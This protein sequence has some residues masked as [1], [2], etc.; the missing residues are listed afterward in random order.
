MRAVVYDLQ[1]IQ[2]LFLKGKVQ[3]ESGV[4]CYL[5]QQSRF[6]FRVFLTDAEGNQYMG[7]LSKFQ[8]TPHCA[9]SD[10][11]VFDSNTEQWTNET[12]GAFKIM[13]TLLARVGLL[14]FYVEVQGAT[15]QNFRAR[16]GLNHVK[17][18]WNLQ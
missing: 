4:S 8:D 14:G 9:L 6:N 2:D 7:Q 11:F 17:N 15:A 12:K 3:L 16:Q 5:Q 10:I 1:D 18:N 13:R